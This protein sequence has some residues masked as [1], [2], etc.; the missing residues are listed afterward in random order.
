MSTRPLPI[1]DAGDLRLE[2]FLPYRLSVLANRV[3]RAIAARYEKD[4]DLTIPEWRV[5]AVL[6]PAGAMSATDIA[7]ATEMDKVAI[8]RAVAKLKAAGRLA[9][10]A[11][12]A[13]QRRQT[14]SLTAAGVAVYRRI[15]PL[16]RGYEQRLLGALTPED[17]TALDDV[18]TKLAKAARA[19]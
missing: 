11:D 2:S 1:S 19:L 7:D 10:R 8:S 13:D 3:S 9:A 14:L 5:M 16:A 17:R 4:F 18:L 6:G 15:V 12:A